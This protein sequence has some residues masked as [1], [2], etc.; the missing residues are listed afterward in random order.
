VRHTGKFDFDAG[1]GNPVQVFSLVDLADRLLGHLRQ[2]A[3]GGEPGL[4]SYRSIEPFTLATVIQ[5]Q[6]VDSQ[7]EIPDQ[8][9]IH[10]ALEGLTSWRA[11]WQADPLPPIDQR[12]LEIRTS[13]KG[14][15]LYGDQ[16]GQV[17][18]LPG[19]FLQPSTIPLLASYHRNLLLASVHTQS[20]SSFLRQT[21]VW[22]HSGQNLKAIHRW[23][24]EKA[25]DLLGGLYSGKD[26]YKSFS[27][28]AQIIPYLAAI[29]AFGAEL[30]FDPAKYQ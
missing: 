20:L 1:D 18:W 21:S 28:R 24:V 3:L 2:Q 19:L 30:Y 8:G 22:S 7:A 5:G 27:A 25:Y 23:A 29:Q 14:H 10:R 12:K 17:A 26:T 16:S 13:P 15:T 11:T 6:G 9:E 4:A